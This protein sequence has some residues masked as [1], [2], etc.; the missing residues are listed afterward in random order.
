MKKMLKI[1]ILFLVI[2]FL[3]LVF[4]FFLGRAPKQ[5][6]ILWGVNFSQ[7][8]AERFG[9]GWKETYLAILEDLKAKNIKL[10]IN[11]D[12]VNGEKD[13]YYFN[14][15]DWQVKEAENHGVK[16]IMV[17]GMKTGRWPECHI[18]KWAESLSKEERENE[19]LKYIEAM[20]LRYKSSDAI[21]SWQVE[22]EPFFPF[23]Q[24]PKIDE[25]FVKKEVELVKSLDH[26][27]RPVIISDTGELSLWLKPARIGDIVG[28]TLYKKVWSKELGI[29]FSAPFPPLSY[30]WKA[31]LIKALY[32]KE[33]QCIEL[34]A[35][36]W[37]P[38]LLYDLSLEEQKKTMDLD[39]FK[40][41]V[42]FAEKT[43]LN[44]FYFWGTEWWYQMKTKYNDS[45]I[46]DEAKKLFAK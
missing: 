38:V 22:N 11:W 30:Y 44:V 3:F 18:P 34:Q 7:M 33:V 21:I 2:C 23:G 46:W 12:W 29:Y 24:C 31:Q 10:V 43:G 45:S 5:K 9:L 16:L 6:N 42:N 36:P 14:D 8:Q 40:Y 13:N 20:V 41:T 25:S 15:V 4:Y 19:V 39:K 26:K 32:G 1:I 37:G 28:N 17:L 35:E 27:K